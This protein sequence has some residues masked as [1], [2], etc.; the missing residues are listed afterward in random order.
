MKIYHPTDP[1]I[2]EV[3]VSPSPAIE[4]LGEVQSSFECYFSLKRK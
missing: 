3:L 1:E 4:E 2:P